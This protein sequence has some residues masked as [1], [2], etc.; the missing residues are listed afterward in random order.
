MAT[1]EPVGPIGSGDKDGSNFICCVNRG[2]PQSHTVW[3]FGEDGVTRE[4]H[5]T[6][7]VDVGAGFVGEFSINYLTPNWR[8]VP[9][10]GRNSN[11]GSVKWLGVTDFLRND[12]PP[13]TLNLLAPYVK[14]VE[15]L[16][17]IT[18]V[19]T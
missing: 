7:R 11:N 18:T 4:V 1:R 8:R 3:I 6:A 12:G 5:P 14:N 13:W 15:N 2:H 9:I 17:A 10:F 19:I 16:Y